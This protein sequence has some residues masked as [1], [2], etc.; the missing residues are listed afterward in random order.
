MISI[1][2]FKQFRLYLL[3]GLLLA[4]AQSGCF[5]GS[6]DPIETDGDDVRVTPEEGGTLVSSDGRAIV[7][8]VAGTVSRPTT[9]SISIIPKKNYPDQYF[10][11]SDVYQIEPTL[12]LNQ[13]V[14]VILDMEDMGST[15]NGL[16]DY[17]NQNALTMREMLPSQAPRFLSVDEGSIDGADGKKHRV[18]VFET[19]QLGAYGVF[20]HDCFMMCQKTVT[21]DSF[22]GNPD[23]SKR[24]QIQACMQ[25]FGCLDDLEKMNREDTLATF[26]C[27]AH[28]PCKDSFG[29][30][31]EETH[32][33][34][35]VDGD[36]DQIDGD[37][38]GD[39]P[40]GDQPDG[41]LPD[42][43][44]DSIDAD[45]DLV[46]GDQ[47]S[48]SPKLCQSDDDCSTSETCAKSSMLGDDGY[49]LT[50]STREMETYSLVQDVWT[51]MNT[52]PNIDCVGDL[53]I[54]G[55]TGLNAFDLKVTVDPFWGLDDPSGIEIRVYEESNLTTPLVYGETDSNGS[56]TFAQIY[57]DKW[58]MIRAERQDD[59]ESKH[60]MPTYH[61]GNFITRARA[62]TQMD[63]AGYVEL[64]VHPLDERR[65]NLFGKT[66][67]LGDTV[68]SGSGMIL[69]QVADCRNPTP[70]SIANTTV[71]YQEIVPT[72]HG[73]FSSNATQP[74]PDPRQSISNKN[75]LF[76]S[77][78]D[79]AAIDTLP[80]NL[81]SAFA[82]GI[83][84][85]TGT[86]ILEVAG[87]SYSDQLRI[88]SDSISIVRF[89]SYD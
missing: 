54:K 77:V 3:A 44:M 29:C 52:R 58:L 89:N 24:E 4:L 32:C 82:V 18:L 13:S 66:L 62:Q 12:P 68:P 78:F 43:D 86:P 28:H 61:W 14:R 19:D 49:C 60:I 59:D 6:P 39:Q 83:S 5:T 74:A 71:S 22:L 8:F 10:L 48:Y 42:G 87:I 46:D 40:D 33:E 51:P 9:F 11:Q 64:T 80:E 57:A 7:Q 31:L 85:L 26:D 65:Y 45:Q 17:Y 79:K 53:P 27:S 34:V 25:D 41:D 72:A 30:C 20:L 38:D 1:R 69:G 76:I 84:E 73:Y 70:Y 36:P 47:P 75:G 35:P 21:C 56:V 81:I 23:L 2:T 88:Q 16:V 15:E 37:T 63:S 50:V 55:T 67:G